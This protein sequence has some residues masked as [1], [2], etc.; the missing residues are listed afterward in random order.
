M[1][2]FVIVLLV[3]V[4]FLV[5]LACIALY[6][7]RASSPESAIRR[8]RWSLGSVFI[9]VLLGFMFAYSQANQHDKRLQQAQQSFNQISDAHAYTLIVFDECIKHL[10]NN[11]DKCKTTT[12]HKV[13]ASNYQAQWPQLERDLN[14]FIAASYIKQ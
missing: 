7:A 9:V 11:I 1:S 2:V 4:L 3:S 5:S 12:Y 14:A 6:V 8:A 10:G 13:N